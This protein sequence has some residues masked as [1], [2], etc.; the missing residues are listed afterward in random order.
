MAS[1]QHRID[2]TLAEVEQI[3]SLIHPMGDPDP[4]QNL[5]NARSRREDAVRVTVIQMS[6]AIEDM[7]DGLSEGY[8]WDTIR[9][10]RNA[11][12]EGKVLLA[13]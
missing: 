13:N 6:L 8:W 5:Y 7:L 10:Q 12:I 11:E 1:V 4:R 2:K 3:H 9:F